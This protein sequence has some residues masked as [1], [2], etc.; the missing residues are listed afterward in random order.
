MQDGDP[1][2]VDVPKRRLDVDISEKEMEKR[3]SNWRPPDQSHIT[4]TLLMYATSALQADQGAGWP[5]R[6]SDLDGR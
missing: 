5:V 3:K 4:G 6:W 2:V 1:I